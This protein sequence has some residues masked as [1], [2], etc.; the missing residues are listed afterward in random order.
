M[1]SLSIKDLS[2][3]YYKDTDV[4]KNMTASFESYRI[5]TLLGLNGSGK[6][7]LIKLLAGLFSPKEGVVN[8]GEKNLKDIDY[9]TRSH[10]IAYVRQGTSTGDDHYVKDYLS[11]GMMN[12]LSWYK[13][14]SLE[15]MKIVENAAKKFNILNLMGKKMNE[16]SGG[17]KQVVMICRAFI[18]N[19]D[20]I[21]LDEPTS[22]L[23]FKN[24]SLVLKILKEIVEKENKTIILST[25]NPNHAL[26]LE[27]EVLLIHEG[28][29]VDN[30]P[31]N[32][33]V[34]VEKLRFVYGDTVTYSA[35]LNY[36]EVT[37]E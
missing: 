33:L 5:H 30:G 31:A 20:I 8:L 17:Q 13:S 4:I 10:H 1:K 26:F 14:P 23:D 18:Q 21:I 34:T 24:Q 7:T 29:I 35:S 37:I 16:L 6:T 3:A 22:A 25:H 15:Q 11:F 36:N 28:V 27:S 2:Y 9:L 19:T 32:K 12:I